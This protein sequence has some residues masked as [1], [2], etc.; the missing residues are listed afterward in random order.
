MSIQDDPSAVS[1]RRGFSTVWTSVENQAV[2]VAR[3]RSTNICGWFGPATVSHEVPVPEYPNDDGIVP[4][5]KGLACERLFEIAR[6]LGLGIL[7]RSGSS[8]D[9]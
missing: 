2:R 5:S 1:R 9:V 3:P 6:A 8:P 7:V 4:N